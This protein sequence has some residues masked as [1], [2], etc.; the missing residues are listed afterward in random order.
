MRW[1]AQ[2]MKAQQAK[3]GHQFP[4][5]LASDSCS[6]NGLEQQNGNCQSLLHWYLKAPK[7]SSRGSLL[8]HLSAMV[9]GRFQF[10][11]QAVPSLL[12]SIFCQEDGRWA[13]VART[14]E[15]PH[16]IRNF[17]TRKTSLAKAGSTFRP[18]TSI[19]P[20]GGVVSSLLK[21]SPF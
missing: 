19:G 8:Q 7:S 10:T 9:P 20:S 3:A 16:R 13:L 1:S 21:F 14:T 15:G 18:F 4:A 2:T 12:S 17:P 5:T 6:S 11:F